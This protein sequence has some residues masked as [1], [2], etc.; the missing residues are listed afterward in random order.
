MPLYSCQ[1]YVQGLINGLAMP[2]GVPGPLTAWITPPVAEKL[3]APRAY[4]WGG[5]VRASRQTAPRGPGFKK[6]PWIVDIYLAYMDNPDNALANEPFAQVIDA[7]TE[8]FETATMPVFISPAG[9]VVVESS[10]ADATYSQIQ[11]VGES[12][13]LQYP[14]EK[15]VLS[16]RQIWYSSLIS[17]DVLEVIQ[18]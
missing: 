7:V 15:S 18:Q 1:K 9:A 12:W 14:P 5:R 3:Q 8:V 13:D 16:Q 2:A 17:M 4:V 6:R 10:A 11:A